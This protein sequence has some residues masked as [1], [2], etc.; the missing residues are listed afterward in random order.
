MGFCTLDNVA[1][2]HSKLNNTKIMTENSSE[3]KGLKI[4]NGDY[5]KNRF[6]A[7]MTSSSF[8][9]KLILVFVAV[10]SAFTIVSKIGVISEQ[11]KKTEAL[12]NK[13]AELTTKVEELK[14]L[15]QYVGT[16]EYIEQAARDKLG[17]V[18]DGEI[19]FRNENATD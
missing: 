9:C 5:V 15:E 8:W 11:K 1:K 16:D 14:A 3:K 18:K 7:K 2:K 10:Y 12:L 13:K 6:M 17:W 19:L 4:E